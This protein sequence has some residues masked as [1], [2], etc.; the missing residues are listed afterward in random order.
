M[1][2]VNNGPQYRENKPPESIKAE[3]RELYDQN[4]PDSEYDE[5][6]AQQAQRKQLLTYGAYGVIAVVVIMVLFSMWRDNRNGSN[7]V[8]GIVPVTSGTCQVVPVTVLRKDTVSEFGNTY[9][10]YQLSNNTYIKTYGACSESDL[11]AIGAQMQQTS[12]Q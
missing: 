8:Q 6:E 3:D 11:Y 1:P 12:C 10:K 2:I 7:S 5:Y 9:C 4:S